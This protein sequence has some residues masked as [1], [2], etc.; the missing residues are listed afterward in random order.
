MESRAGIGTRRGGW[1]G[2]K[3]RKCFDS[4]RQPGGF[5][6]QRSSVKAMKIATFYTSL[7]DAQWAFLKRLLPKRPKRG[8]PPTDRRRIMDAL[9]YVVK[10][11]IQWRLLPASFPP[12]KTVY[13][14]FRQWTL[15]HTW[16]ALNARLR[17]HVRKTHDKR[18]R[19]TA[20][21]LDSQSVKSDGHGGAVGYD[22]AKKIK[23]RKR[24]LLVDT[25]GLV[26]GV[27]VTP[28]STPER[29]GAQALLARILVWFTWL[30][31]LWVDGGYSGVTFAQWVQGI[32][33]R[34][35]V[36]VVKRS[37]DVKGFRVLPRRWVVER[38]FGWL[39]RHRRL[40]RDYETTETSAQAWV[41]VAMIRIQL[42]RLA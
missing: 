7:T 18:A 33:P 3:V 40:V 29:E 27:L 16:E 32:R 31:L 38:T 9:L 42:R 24:H 21:I 6:F 22:A 10:G 11:G 34:L 30:R 37:D 25:L 17:T 39:M 14:V 28:A 1:T 41:Y 13:H 8:R 12:W 15:N 36:E 26:L 20:A 2:R 19:P 23:G 4:A 35:Q 5:N